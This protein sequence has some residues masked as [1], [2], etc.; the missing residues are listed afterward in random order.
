[1]IKDFIAT[2]ISD[3]FIVSVSMAAVILCVFLGNFWYHTYVYDSVSMRTDDVAERFVFDEHG[4][5]YGSGSMQPCLSPDAELY[6][7]K[8]EKIF[9]VSVGDVVVY[10]DAEQISVVHRVV[11]RFVV[12]EDMVG[13]TWLVVQGDNNL[14]PDSDLVLESAVQKKVVG[15]WKE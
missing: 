10:T 5:V 14:Y 9:P 12:S 11:K 13:K 2:F 15:V 6:Y 1:M 3:M 4:G 8:G 7:E